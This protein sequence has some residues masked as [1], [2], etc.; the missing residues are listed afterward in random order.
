MKIQFLHL[1]SW[2]AVYAMQSASFCTAVY[3][4]VLMKVKALLGGIE[5]SIRN[6]ALIL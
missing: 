3:V 1:L 5:V 2:S 6:E 4:L